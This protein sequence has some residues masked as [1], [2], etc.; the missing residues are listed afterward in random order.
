MLRWDHVNFLL[1]LASNEDPPDLHFTSSWDY[2]LS[3]HAH[4]AKSWELIKGSF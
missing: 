1:G 2:S 4:L 3:H